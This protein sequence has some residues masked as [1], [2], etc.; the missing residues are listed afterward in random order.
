MQNTTQIIFSCCR[1]L[2]TMLM[3]NF[4]SSMAESDNDEQSWE[5][6]NPNRT[7]ILPPLPQARGSP[8]ILP[9]AEAELLACPRSKVMH[10]TRNYNYNFS[11]VHSPTLFENDT[12]FHSLVIPPFQK[13]PILTIA[14]SQVTQSSTCDDF[15]VGKGRGTMFLFSGCAGI[16][17]TT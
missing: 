9:L 8:R 14:P 2:T 7:P 1:S 17:E 5:D 6:A 10:S 4:L 11:L 3:R 13:E 16:G 15:I 12:A